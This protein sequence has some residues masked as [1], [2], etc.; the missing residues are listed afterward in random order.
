M[1][2]YSRTIK[3]QAALACIATLLTCAAHAAD[4]TWVYPGSGNTNWNRAANWSGSAAPANNDLLTFAGAAGLG[5]TN[6]IGSLSINGITFAASAGTFTLGGQPLTITG[7]I[8]NNSTNTQTLNFNSTGITLGGIMTVSANSG[9]LFFSTAVNLNGNAL[10][11]VGPNLVTFDQKISGTSANSM[12]VGTAGGISGDVVLNANNNTLGS[13]VVLLSGTVTVN[14]G[15][16]LGND[17]FTIF[18]SGTSTGVT[19]QTGSDSVNIT[20]NVDVESS[21]NVAAATSG[22]TGMVLSG[23]VSLNTGSGTNAFTITALNGNTTRFAGMIRQ[24]GTGVASLTL[25]GGGVGGGFVFGGS[26]ANTYTGL[27]TVTNGASL[28]LNHPDNVTAIAGDL[29]IDASSLVRL[30]G[31]NL[32]ADTSNVTANGTFD[33]NGNNETIAS[34]SGTGL[35][36]LDGAALTLGSGT[37]GGDIRDNGAG[38]SLVK[39]GTN[40]L[41]LDTANHYSGGTTLNSGTLLA[42]N[43]NAIGTGTLTINGTSSTLGS[44]AGGLHL[45]NAVVALTS[46]KVAPSGTVASGTLTMNGLVTLNT[47]GGT[48]NFTIMQ[49]N[50]NVFRLL[51]GIA[52]SGTGA[53]SLT[54]DGGGSGVAGTFRIGD[55]TAAYT[56]GGLTTVTNFATLIL[57]NSGT[58]AAVPGN[59]QIDAGSTVRFIANPDQIADTATVTDNGTLNLNGRNETIATLLGSGTVQTGSSGTFT[60]SNGTFSGGINGSNSTFIK[61]GTG[62][63]LLTGANLM[64]GTT[65]INGG[66]LILDGTIGAAMFANSGAL[67][68][69]GFVANTLVNASLVTP[70]HLNAPGIFTTKGY[71]QTSAG[72]LLLR[73]GGVGPGQSDQLANAGT[74]TLDGTLQLVR[75]NNFQGALGQKITL[76]TS[77]GLSGSFANTINPFQTNTLVKA[78]IVYDANNVYL[79]FDQGSFLQFARA[80]GLTPNEIAVAGGLDSAAGSPGLTALFG[81]LDNEPLENLPGDLALIS[82]DKLTEIFDISRAHADVQGANIE[83]RL[84]DDRSETGDNGVTVGLVVGD[85]K[86]SVDKNVTTVDAHRENRWGLFMAGS[87]EFIHANGD[88]NAAGYDFTTGG[89]TLGADYR[90]NNHLV[91]GLMMGYANTASTL[92][93]NGSLH[94]NA[95]RLG[96]YSTLYGNGLYL[97]AMAAGGYNSYDTH[98]LGLG[99]IARGSTQGGEFDGLLSSGY[100]ARQGHFRFGPVVSLQYTYVGIDGFNEAGSLAPLNV[101]SQSQG[102]LRSKAGFRVAYDWKVRGVTVT[103]GVSAG[104][105]HEYLNSAFALDSQFANGAGN[106]FTV[107]G[108]A[109]GRDS[110]VVNA[111][112]SVQWT[113]RIGTYLYYDGELGRKNY[114]LNAVTGG[115]KLSF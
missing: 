21:F 4:R 66:Q 80:H 7:T 58:N 82:P 112:V 86:S 47:S 60:V 83:N 56:Y 11:V 75:L 67:S 106:I 50:G 27:T 6:N 13:S 68:G 22:T 41:E 39:N 9:Q 79:S 114:Q 40:T 38:G 26:S 74:A 2:K 101:V 69:T 30:Q 53:A 63:L 5:N 87:G 77:E 73:I 96:L 28:V 32:I 97:N 78:E 103:P 57:N 43:T 91:A 71:I 62:T 12:F 98:R 29:Q 19:F 46:F 18:K 85:G 23:T 111:G 107:R 51:G 31:A 81:F 76:V 49:T 109:F 36:R 94:V 90:V 3:L 100:E 64:S 65:N 48:T 35:V 15:N 55:S 88:G 99:G 8:A 61:T 59:L 25:N 70:G 1:F 110:V 44:L 24:T 14:N 93:S 16:A 84:A 42:N 92:G 108:P 54:Y 52:Q 72:T 102:S 95:G 105:Q 37:F 20:T 17:I 113:P 104:W 115:M 10:T 89:I 34:L 33:V 45:D